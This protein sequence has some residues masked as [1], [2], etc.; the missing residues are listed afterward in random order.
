MMKGRLIPPSQ[1]AFLYQQK[2][3]ADRLPN[4]TELST[5]W[6]MRPP[7]A[8]GPNEAPVYEARKNPALK[9]SSNY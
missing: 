5:Q 3:T 8:L 2:D 4:R 1:K 9:P 7:W 6:I